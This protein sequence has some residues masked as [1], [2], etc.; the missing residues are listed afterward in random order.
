M[1]CSQCGQRKGLSL[2]GSK[3]YGHFNIGFAPGVFSGLINYT[4]KEIIF[5]HVFRKMSE[6]VMLY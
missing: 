1:Y 3:Q 5:Y 6:G 2:R 4:I